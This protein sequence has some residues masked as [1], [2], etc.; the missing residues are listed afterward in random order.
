MHV[1]WIVLED[2]PVFKVVDDSN[3]EVALYMGNESH[4]GPNEMHEIFITLV[5]NK[6]VD[7]NE[8]FD[9]S[10]DS[11]D[12][13]E[14]SVKSISDNRV[15]LKITKR[16]NDQDLVVI[17]SEENK[18]RL[19]RNY[20]TEFQKFINLLG[21]AQIERMQRGYEH[22]SGFNFGLDTFEILKKFSD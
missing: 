6:H 7:I 16:S 14:F 10:L 3:N 8:W 9:G 20:I 2:T 21:K 22:D 13:Y 18:D 19:I 12:S 5:N 11:Y 17:N 1:S 4:E 15:K